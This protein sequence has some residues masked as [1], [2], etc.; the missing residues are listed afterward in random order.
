MSVF[1]LESVVYFLK[2]FVKLLL[3]RPFGT[4]EMQFSKMEMAPIFFLVSLMLRLIF[5]SPYQIV[6]RIFCK[7]FG[8]MVCRCVPLSLYCATSVS[9]NC[10][11]HK[12]MAEGGVG[13]GFLGACS[14]G[15]FECIVEF[16]CNFLHFLD[17]N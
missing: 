8:S 12:L 4:V 13:E 3:L 9:I 17:W 15:K 6:I 2:V 5:K 10:W 16:K 7:T 14:P 11:R 1:K